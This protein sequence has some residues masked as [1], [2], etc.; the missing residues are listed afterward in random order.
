MGM[1]IGCVWRG[2][3]GENLAPTA[4]LKEGSL[5]TIKEGV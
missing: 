4:R 1:L 5:K 3:E 2:M